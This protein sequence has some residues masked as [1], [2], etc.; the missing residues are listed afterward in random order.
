MTGASRLR[1]VG[2]G[3]VARR[4]GLFRPRAGA[5]S[6]PRAHL[7]GVDIEFVTGDL[8]D[9]ASLAPAMAGVRYLFHVAADYRLWA[10]DPR[11]IIENNVAGTRAIMDAALR[12]GV[13]RIDLHQQRRDA[14]RC[15]RTA[16]RSMRACRSKRLPRSAPTR[17]ARSPRSG[18]SKR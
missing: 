16:S 7:D 4:E 12:A 8:R 3:Q 5:A 18:W 10:R 17:K 14:A 9:P 1:R 2:G 11:E 6:S 13:E 15:G